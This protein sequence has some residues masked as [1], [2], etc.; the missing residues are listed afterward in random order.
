MEVP[1]S[2]CA[3]AVRQLLGPARIDIS[4]AL[5]DRCDSHDGWQ[6]SL[7]YMGPES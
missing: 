1:S 7:E 5:A 3:G 2:E 4:A 6:T